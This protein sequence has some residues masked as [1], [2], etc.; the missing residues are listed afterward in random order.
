MVKG[1]ADAGY[2]PEVHKLE[3][4]E[5]DYGLAPVDGE[6]DLGS[7]EDDEAESDEDS[8]M[9]FGDEESMSKL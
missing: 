8:E 9:G 2:E 3:H 4:Y 7:D 6:D 1:F 5:D